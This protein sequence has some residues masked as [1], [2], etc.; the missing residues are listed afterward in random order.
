MKQIVLDE[1]GKAY[2]KHG[3]DFNSPHEAY[4]VIKE[5][6]EETLDRLVLFRDMLDEFW[7]ACRKDE[8]TKPLASFMFIAADEALTELAQVA[9]MCI[10]AKK[11]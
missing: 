5:E 4:A 11:L 7:M 2:E 10:K 6:F 3:K 9:A 1:L 8:S